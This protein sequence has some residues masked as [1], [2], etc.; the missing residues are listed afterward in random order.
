MSNES[1]KD[2]APHIIS[3]LTLTRIAIYWK[4]MATDV[5]LIQYRKALKNLTT[6]FRANLTDSFSCK[7]LTTIQ[8]SNAIAQLTVF[9]PR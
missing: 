4:Y 2:T 1:N 6:S 7:C 9:L 5:I 3:V 8:L